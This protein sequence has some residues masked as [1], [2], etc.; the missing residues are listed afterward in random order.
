MN[1]KTNINLF[2]FL[3]SL[4]IILFSFSDYKID[5]TKNNRFTLNPNTL[6]I[7]KEFDQKI[8]IDVFLSGKLPKSYRKLS[9]E[10]T[11]LLNSFKSINN[12][13]KINFINPFEDDISI[14]NLVNEMNSYGMKPQYVIDENNQSIEKKIIYPWAII[15]D[16]NNSVLISLIE[17]HLG[18]SNE[19]KII[20]GI[21]KLEYK[22]SDGIQRLIKNSK[23]KIAF[24]SSHG[25]SPT[26]KITDWIKKLQ[27]YYE[28]S[29][30]D[31]NKYKN[32]TKETFDN[33]VTYPLLIISNPKEKFTLEEIYI[34]D[35]YK[36]YGGN[37]LWLIDG[38]K[39]DINSLIKNNGKSLAI[40]NDLGL[41]NY[42][43]NYGLR[44]NTELVKDIYCAP[45]VIASGNGNQTQFIPFPWIYY[46][47]NNAKKSVIN[48]SDTGGVW[49]RFVS[50]I[51]TLKNSLKNTYLATS[52]NYT[53]IQEIPS[54]IDLSIAG[55]KLNPEEFILKESLFAVLS[56]GNRTSLFKNR[57]SPLSSIIK[58]E[59]GIGKLILVSDGQFGEN[60]LDNSNNP[61]ELGYDKWTNNF[62]S[63]KK[64]LMN[65]VH[66][67][68][69]PSFLM[70]I[71]LRKIKISL[72]D[73]VKIS[74]RS[75]YSSFLFL[76]I[77]ILLLLVLNYFVN[78]NRNVH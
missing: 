48:R 25:T 78:K 41:D 6:S 24:L 66:Y 31:L 23:S 13:L 42:F 26:I 47:V 71:E 35:Q 28:V 1:N 2:L 58:K 36:L 53:Q 18:D 39:I 43:F 57:V 67:I 45:L 61:L 37:I 54:E 5:F 22:F 65:T 64:F 56:E 3:G 76:I 21:Q 34:L 8:S 46:P 7:L 62:Y 49:F 55:E 11:Q 60:Q 63:N 30:F 33:L 68:V 77:P 74:S 75:H 51:D 32:N 14:E 29:F 12:S 27:T 72:F 59:S 19:Q 10:T 73:Q 44:I 20:K 40:K 9:N 50:P 52:S 16:G 69:E 4:I 17:P 15:N 70:D 38:V